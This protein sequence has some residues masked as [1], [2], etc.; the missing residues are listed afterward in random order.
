MV[1]AGVILLGLAVWRQARDPEPTPDHAPLAVAPASSTTHAIDETPSVP[2]PAMLARLPAL[3]AAEAPIASA[4]DALRQLADAGHVEASCRLS[5]EL[6]RCRNL[7]PFRNL[8]SV[9][10]DF[11]MR[12]Q[13]ETQERSMLEEGKADEADEAALMA[14][15][16]AGLEARCT[17]LPADLD[18]RAGAYLRQAALGGAPEAMVRYANGESMDLNSSN[19]SAMRTPAFDVWRREAP[20]LVQRL[21]DS[22]HPSA[23]LMLLADAEGNTSVYGLLEPVSAQR[24][25]TRRLLARRLFGEHRGLSRFA[26]DTSLDPA[27]VQQAEREAAEQHERQFGGN[28][29]ELVDYTGNVSPLF[30]QHCGTAEDCGWPRSSANRDLPDCGPLP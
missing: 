7:R 10:S 4:V 13:Y 2:T 17:G 1:L 20:G 27:R 5:L 26:A 19:M 30:D 18:A 25:L 23:V 11:S 8:P 9:P 28:R 12:E 3:P 16:Y 15:S 24:D 29:F 21:L 22:G 6:L 14:A